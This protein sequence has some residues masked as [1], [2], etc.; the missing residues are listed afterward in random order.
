MTLKMISV[1]RINLSKDDRKT[2]KALFESMCNSIKETGIM[3]PLTVSE[4][5]TLDYPKY[6]LLD[7]R[8]RFLAAKELGHT[9]VPCNIVEHANE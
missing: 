3:S 6:R 9:E 7:G 2:S 5:C 8:V 4:I 1:K